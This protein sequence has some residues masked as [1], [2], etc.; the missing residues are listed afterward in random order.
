MILVRREKLFKVG[1][2]LREVMLFKTAEEVVKHINKILIIYPLNSYWISVAF[3]VYFL[4]CE[5]MDFIPLQAAHRSP[6][7]YFDSTFSLYSLF[8][9]L[10]S[11][12]TS[13]YFFPFINTAC[14]EKVFFF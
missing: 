2:V 3:V 9:F 5:D 10:I 12:L 6:L 11:F 13:V 4:I 8:A 1:H 14:E 7:L